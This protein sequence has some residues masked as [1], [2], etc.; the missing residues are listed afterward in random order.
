MI[1]YDLLY[2]TIR[3]HRAPDAPPQLCGAA[4]QA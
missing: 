1:L 2:C 3:T 4:A